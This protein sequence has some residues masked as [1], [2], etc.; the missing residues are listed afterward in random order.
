MYFPSISRLSLD[1]AVLQQDASRH[2]QHRWGSELWLNYCIENVDVHVFFGGELKWVH[3][4]NGEN[5]NR[6]RP[7]ATHRNLC[8]S[9]SFDRVGG[10]C[11]NALALAHWHTARRCSSGL[12]QLY[13]NFNEF[14]RRPLPFLNHPFISEWM[15]ERHAWDNLWPLSN[16]FLTWRWWIG[17][18]NDYGN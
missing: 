18:G 11:A 5:F 9:Q 1:F 16:V 17:C 4:F 7:H 14:T 2:I 13:E 8:V 3:L 10:D 12:P 6:T 15:C